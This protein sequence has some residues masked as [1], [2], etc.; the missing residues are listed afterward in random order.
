MTT[1]ASGWASASV[2]GGVDSRRR[3]TAP[4]SRASSRRVDA[5]P[6]GRARG[7]RT[8]SRRPAGGVRPAAPRP[9]RASTAPRRRS[10]RAARARARRAAAIAVDDDR[11]QRLAGAASKAGLPAVVDLDEVEQRAEHAVDAGQ[12]LGAGPGA[13]RVEGELQRLGPGRPGAS[14][15]SAASWRGLG[16]ARAAP[17]A[18][19]PRRLGL[20]ELGRRAAPRPLGARRSRS[21]SRSASA[22]SR[23]SRSRSA[24]SAGCDRD[25]ARVSPRSTRGAQRAQLA[26][27]LGRGASPP[28][29]RRRRRPSD[30]SKRRALARRSA[31]PRPASVVGLGR[32]RGERRVDRRRARRARRAASASRVAMTPASS[33]WPR[34]RSSE[35]RRSASTAARPRPARA[36]ARRARRRRRGRRRRAPTARPRRPAT[37][38]S[39]RASA[40]LELASRRR[41]RSIRSTASAVELAPQRRRSR[42]RRGTAQRR[43]LGDELAVAAGRLGLA[44]ERAQLAAHLAQQVL[45]AQQVGLGGVEPALGLLL[46]LAVLQDAG[47]LLDDR[48]AVLGAGVEHGVDL[49]LADDHVLLAADAGVGEQLLDVEQPARARR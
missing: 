4:P 28:A 45:H 13:G 41:R 7:A 44:L 40:R 21:R 27:H 22:A 18:E 31:A 26:A 10:T 12:A 34:S 42:G 39:S 29:C 46:A 20:L 16:C 32:E 11:A 1:T 35:R 37:S 38:V 17:S 2:D 25:A 49:A 8:G 47:G 24:A 5:G 14:A 43:Q 9:P 19:S 33:S 48:P 3:A 6:A 30:C 15:A 23:S 36:A